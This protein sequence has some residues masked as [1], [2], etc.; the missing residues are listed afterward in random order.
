MSTH[1]LCFFI[2]IRKIMYTSVN[3]S[4]TIN[5]WGLSR[6][7]LYRHVLVMSD[8]VYTVSQAYLSMYAK[9]TALYFQSRNSFFFFILWPFQKFF[10]YIKPIVHQRWAK[11]GESGEKPP[12]HP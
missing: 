3:P 6:S 2:K 9:N 11:T 4:F 5:K 1:N 10:T 7:K 8:L 12:D